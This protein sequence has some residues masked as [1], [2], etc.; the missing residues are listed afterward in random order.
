MDAPLDVLARAARLGWRVARSLRQP[1]ADTTCMTAPSAAGRR[2]RAMKRHVNSIANSLIKALPF[3]DE[4]LGRICQASD[5]IDF[6][7]Y[8]TIYLGVDEVSLFSSYVHDLKLY[9]VIGKL[10][11]DP[12]EAMLEKTV[13]ALKH[14]F[15]YE[16]ILEGLSGRDEVYAVDLPYL[17]EANSDLTCA[18]LL[19]A[20]DRHKAAAHSL[21][22]ALEVAVA[23]AYLSVKC[24]VYEDLRNWLIPP[25]K[26]KKRGMLNYLVEFEFISACQAEEVS[27][28]YRDL[29]AATHSQH[30]YLV[31]NLEQ[32]S[33]AGIFLRSLQ[34]VREVSSSCI[35]L[36][37]RMDSYQFPEEPMF[38]SEASR[39]L[40]RDP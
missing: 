35:A 40:P 10:F 24:L 39:Q 1:G 9:E 22:S 26:D 37:I 33:E 2:K 20:N 7:E 29:S 34:N 5:V 3:K 38:S 17:D 30:R 4:P 23:H 16:R 28:L 8:Y 36:I 15:A 12:E 13:G 21:R 11:P 6:V 32:P 14:T 18:L 25:M 27:S 19:I 31:R